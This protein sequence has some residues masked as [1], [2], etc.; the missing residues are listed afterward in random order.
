MQTK[1]HMIRHIIT[2]GLNCLKIQREHK[3]SEDNY[4]LQVAYSDSHSQ[5]SST[6]SLLYA[7]IPCAQGFEIIINE[8]AI[9]VIAAS[10]SVII[11]YDIICILHIPVIKSV[12]IRMSGMHQRRPLPR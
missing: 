5:G 1:I 6:Y 11:L 8:M 2:V 7:C 9:A 4:N 3:E 12:R 10:C